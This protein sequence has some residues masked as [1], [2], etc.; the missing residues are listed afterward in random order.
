M[1]HSIAAQGRKIAGDVAFYERVAR[2]S[3]GL[4]SS[5]PAVLDG[6]NQHSGGSQDPPDFLYRCWNIF[7]VHQRVVS[8][9][10]IESTVQER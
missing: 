8:H 6:D 10:E 7:D 1:T 3:A 2:E 4:S 9:Y 5:S